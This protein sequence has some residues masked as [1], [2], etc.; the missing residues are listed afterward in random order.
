MVAVRCRRRLTVVPELASS[1]GLLRRGA[2]CPGSASYAAACIASLVPST[3]GSHLRQAVRAQPVLQ[4]HWISGVGLVYWP[5]QS[6]AKSIAA[7]STHSPAARV[8][9]GPMSLYKQLGGE[10]NKMGAVGGLTRG[11]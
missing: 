6:R 7:A 10:H 9:I 2:L 1:R 8:L 4:G 11:V 3:H 5:N